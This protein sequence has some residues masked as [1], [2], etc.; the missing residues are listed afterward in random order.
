[1]GRRANSETNAKRY[2]HGQ[3]YF[4]KDIGDII[5]RLAALEDR[6]SAQM[7]KRLILEALRT[8]GEI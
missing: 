6:S 8:R 4:D 1:M 7:C 5:K 2:F 3:V